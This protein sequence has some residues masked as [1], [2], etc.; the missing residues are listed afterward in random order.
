MPILVAWI[1][2]NQAADAEITLSGLLGDNSLTLRSLAF[3]RT[4]YEQAAPPIT[5]TLGV[6]VLVPALMPLFFY[7]L[8][9]LVRCLR[10]NKVVTVSEMRALF[11]GPPFYFAFRVGAATAYM[12][13][14]LLFGPGMPLIY[15]V[16]VL[17]FAVNYWA[18]RWV[19][20]GTRSHLRGGLVWAC[21]LSARAQSRWGCPP[22]A[23]EA[24]HAFSRS[25]A[26]VR[27]GRPAARL[28]TPRR[29]PKTITPIS[30]A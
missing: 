8:G 13:L 17:Y 15:L 24:S 25:H 19:G 23:G 11:R 20:R 27:E 28:A 16:G 6:M 22:R 21:D 9:R 7:S 3:D 14:V 4:F 1:S 30:Q 2:R 18:R 10:I 29:K 26:A 12:V 5:L